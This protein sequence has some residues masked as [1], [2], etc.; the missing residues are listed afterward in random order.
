MGFVAASG[1]AA[2]RPSAR[3]AR[4]RRYDHVRPIRPKRP[5]L[6][7]FQAGGPEPGWRARSLHSGEGGGLT[8][9]EPRL[10]H[11]IRHLAEQRPREV[12]EG[13]GK[14]ADAPRPPHGAADL[15]PR[16][17]QRC[18]PTGL[19]HRKAGPGD[20]A[21]WSSRRR[22][23]ARAG[24][25]RGWLPRRIVGVRQRTSPLDDERAQFPR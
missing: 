24:R 11:V 12:R 16:H 7:R 8:R 23:R 1:E 21:G 6:V 2:V 20:P 18:S 19:L 9:P 13:R 4:P 5:Y 3:P 22:R 14:T 17:I 10:V 15:E 25:D